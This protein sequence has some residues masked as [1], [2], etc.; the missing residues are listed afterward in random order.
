MKR[1]LLAIAVSIVAVTIS[2][3]FAASKNEETAP[4][5]LPPV[6]AVAQE[7]A[8]L[9][10]KV[11]E[12]MNAGGYTY[13]RIEKNGK[14]IWVAVPPTEIK[15]GQKATFYPGTDMGNFTSKTLN[16]TFDH[17]IFSPGMVAE[18]ASSGVHGAKKAAAPVSTENIKVEK[19]TGPDAFTVSEVHA[20]AGELD[21]KTAVVR[22][23]VVKV[24]EAIMGK[25]W[26]H[27]QDGTGDVSKGNNKLVV[28]SQDLPAVGDVVTVKGVIYKDKDFG[29]GYRYSVIME[30]AAIQH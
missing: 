22:G 19:A 14:K 9:S 13:V 1:A 20:K 6:K 29:A 26:I 28:T 15:V 25:N 12:T 3:G 27:I 30:E 11:V 10:G 4:Q 23:K 5:A 24:S 2:T 16:K 7:D 21:K 17:I 18:G 8:T